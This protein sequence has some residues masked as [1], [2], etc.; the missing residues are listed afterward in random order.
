MQ[1]DTILTEKQQETLNA[2]FSDKG[3]PWVLC[4]GGKG[5]AKTT[6]LVYILIILMTDE[7]YK[8]SKILVARESLRDL[9][10]TLI[11]EF[12]RISNKLGLKLGFAY[13]ENKQL[14]RIYSY[15]NGSEIFYLSLSNKNEQYKTVRSY[16]F[17]VVMIDELDRISKE[18]FIEA[19]ERL[20]YRHNLVRGIVSLNP[21][22]ETH[23][24]YQ[25]FVLGDMKD[26]TYIIK[27]SLYDNFIYVKLP[28]D[29]IKAAELYRFENKTYHVINN[30]R[31]E[32][33]KEDGNFYITKRFNTP[34]SYIVQMEHKPLV[35]R[36]VMV[37]GEWGNAY[38]EADGIYS[39]YFTDNHIAT[40][41]NFNIPNLILFYNFYAGIDFG[42]RRPAY[43]LIAEDSF[44]RLVVVDELIGENEPM[45]VF[46]ENVLLRLKT[47]FNLSARDVEFWG[48]VA[49]TQREQYDGKSIIRKIEDTF[50]IKIYTQRTPQFQSVEA[51]KELLEAKIRDVP[52]LRVHQ[53]CHLTLQ[54]F[55]SEFRYDENGRLLKDGYY[56]HLHDALRYVLYAWWRQNRFKD[57]KIKTPNY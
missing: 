41:I 34:H 1:F 22:P 57:F 33:V 17:N 46:M 11:E 7:K 18:A 10:N 39:L 47:K 20:R 8:E 52:V 6:A 29:V 45:V 19:S 21:V 53:T 32:I 13:D 44:G 9:K 40:D 49:G 5:S 12:F 36:R 38:L 16:E 35:Y 50:K 26:L 24:V 3:K 28:Q 43:C 25:T 27:S 23:W 15:V 37:D 48:D 54:G 42:V 14:Q 51:I 56:D 2:F 31:Y 30:T 55:M 4:V